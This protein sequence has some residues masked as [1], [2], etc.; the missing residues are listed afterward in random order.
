MVEKWRLV[1][2][3]RLILNKEAKEV[4]FRPTDVKKPS[5][6]GILL[7]EPTFDLEFDEFLVPRI[8]WKDNFYVVKNFYPTNEAKG[9]LI[10]AISGLTGRS[11]EPVFSEDTPDAVWFVKTGTQDYKDASDEMIR[12]LNC[13]MMKKTRKWV[14][15]HR[16]DSENKTYFYL[17]KFVSH[18]KNYDSSEFLPIPVECH[19]V[20][21]KIPDG[22]DTIPDILRCSM[23]GST[24]RDYIHALWGNLPLMVDSGQVLKD[25]NEPWNLQSLYMDQLKNIYEAGGPLEK[26]LEVFAF[27]DNVGDIFLPESVDLDPIV[28]EIKRS[29]NEL[30]VEWWGLR[31]NGNSQYVGPDQEESANIS[32]LIALFSSSLNQENIFRILYYPE[33]FRMI[34]IDIADIAKNAIINWGS[35]YRLKESY[36]YY[37]KVYDS[38]RKHHREVVDLDQCESR[39]ESFL[40]NKFGIDLSSALKKIITGAASNNGEGVTSWKEINRGSTSRPNIVIQAKVTLQD[41]LCMGEPGETLKNDIINSGFQELSIKFMKDKGVK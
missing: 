15:G 11:L 30:L 39:P 20:I 19:L 29:M 12:R 21:E 6:E 23:Y 16:Y 38:W 7:S 13:S 24:G 37:I 27:T 33:L 9:K 41:I 3:C 8:K 5:N 40:G 32:G 4:T 35:G 34:G 10:K 2:S 28:V 18:R 25:T 17:G 14:P 26:A 22:V 31:Y 1:E 36:D